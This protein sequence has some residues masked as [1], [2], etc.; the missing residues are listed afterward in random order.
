MGVGYGV[1]ADNIGLRS[2]LRAYDRASGFLRQY[3]NAGRIKRFVVIAINART[4]SP[5]Q[6]SH[7]ERSPGLIDVFMK[8]RR[9]AWRP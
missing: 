6:L 3:I 5:E 9:S 8:T 1:L 4:D 2:I 7:R